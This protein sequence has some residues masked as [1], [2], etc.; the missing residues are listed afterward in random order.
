[1]TR[2]KFFLSFEKEEK[3]L[4]KMSR[5]GW[6]LCK[7]GLFY[8]FE[9]T[10]PMPRTIRIDYRDFRKKSDYSSYISMFEDSG[11]RHIAGTKG[12]GSQYF[13]K[14]GSDSTE[15]IFSDSRSRAGRYKRLC[16]MWLCLAVC[17]LPLV[18]S[19]GIDLNY[20]L[21]PKQWY[22][23]PG[24]WELKGLAFLRAFLFETPFALFRGLSLGGGLLIFDIAFLC[25][26]VKSLLSYHREI[27]K[28]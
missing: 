10:E 18:I 24:L 26:A 15:D 14:T 7:I 27:K 28:Q 16:D 20:F 4:E 19:N 3:W 5:Q 17:F 1:M 12:Y 21:T 2:L 13:L 23:T 9:K 6:L 11:W 8:H 25:F 22:L